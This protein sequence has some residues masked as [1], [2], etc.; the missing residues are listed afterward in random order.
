MA[1]RQTERKRT[2]QRQRRKRRKLQKL[3]FDLQKKFNE[4]TANMSINFNYCIL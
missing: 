4:T 3:S 1:R 2:E